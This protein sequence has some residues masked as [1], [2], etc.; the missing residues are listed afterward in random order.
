MPEKV[1]VMAAKIAEADAV[2]IS[3]PE[4]NFTMSSAL[5]NVLDWLSRVNGSN[6]NP[7]ATKPV[8]I[9]SVSAAGTGGLRA[10][11]DL[12]KCLLYFK[13]HVMGLPELSVSENYMKVDKFREPKAENTFVDEKTKQHGLTHI[14]AFV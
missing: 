2:Y 8:A 14:N 4:W 3:T 12:R 13:C 9:A 5:K 11:Y 1:K 10:Q 6:P 7:L